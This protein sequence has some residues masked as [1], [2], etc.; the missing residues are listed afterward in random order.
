MAR[1][2]GRGEVEGPARPERGGPG[3]PG[4]AAWTGPCRPGLGK[5]FR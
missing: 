3:R 1:A 5:L 4:S 2:R